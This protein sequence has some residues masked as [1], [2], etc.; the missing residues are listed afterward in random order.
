MVLAVAQ[1]IIDKIVLE[2]K[3]AFI[4]ARFG[5]FVFNEG[6]ALEAVVILQRDRSLRVGKTEVA[7]ILKTGADSAQGLIFLKIPVKRLPD[8]PKYSS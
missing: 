4:A 8:L 3:R 2:Q 1:Q 7:E 5:L 6:N